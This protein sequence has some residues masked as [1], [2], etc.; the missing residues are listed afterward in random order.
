MSI[1]FKF[2]K[3]KFSLD[4]LE[5]PSRHYY[6]QTGENYIKLLNIGEGVFPKDK[7]R[8]SFK[9]DNSNLILTTESATKI[10]PSKK[11]YGVQ[12]INI[13]LENSSN[14]EF[15]NDELILYK[16]S[17]YI[18]LFNLKCDD[19]STFFYTDILSRGRSFEDFAFS[20][21][22]IKNSFVCDKRV[23]YIEKFDVAGDE[24]KDYIIRKNSHNFI[25]AKIYIK[26]KENENFI[27]NIQEN[28][29]ESF[30]FS[31]NRKIIIGVLSSNNMSN[32]K[33]KVMQVWELY[34]KDLNKE[35]FILGKQ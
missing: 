23:E 33:N 13:T 8:T 30:T 2:E 18:Q 31:H 22:L 3:E 19:S 29:F 20:N 32:L 5:L 11:E 4:K 1:K 21:M 15:L 28:G 9:L 27:K 16:D 17:K 26:T 24:L 10:Y 25:F 35:K 6:F 12:K 34:R 7:L 14:L